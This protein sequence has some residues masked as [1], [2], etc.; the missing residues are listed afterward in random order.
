M[1]SGEKFTGPAE[2]KSV[3]LARK[4]EFLRNITEKMLAYSLGRGIEPADWI[5][6]H[7]IRNTVAKDGFRSQQL[8]LEIAK[9]FPFQH[10]RNQTATKTASIE[11]HD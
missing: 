3:L 11:S 8:V 7:Q 2:M 4:D 10:R 6:V 5:I 1:P 9:S